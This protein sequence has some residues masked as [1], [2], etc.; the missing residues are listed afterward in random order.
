MNGFIR[1]SS[2]KLLLLASISAAATGCQTIETCS[3]GNCGSGTCAA[4]GC[5]ECGPDGCLFG[6]AFKDFKEGCKDFD[7]EQLHTDHCWPDQYNQRFGLT[8]TR[9][10]KARKAN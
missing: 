6:G 9:M 1:K 10:R 8:T 3:T 7:P 5:S 4:G 2:R